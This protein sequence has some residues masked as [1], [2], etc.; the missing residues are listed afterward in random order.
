MAEIDLKEEHSS[1]GADKAINPDLRS[2]VDKKLYDSKDSQGQAALNGFGTSQKV[3]HPYDTPKQVARS[4]DQTT[5]AN[6]CIVKLGR[7]RK[8]NIYSGTGGTHQ[9][10][11]AAIDLVA[12]PMGQ[13]GKSHTKKNQEI[14]VDPSFTHDAARVYISQKADIDDYLDITEGIRSTSL[15]SPK[16]AVA[17]KAD[18]IRLVGREN[19]KLIT[20][21]DAENSQGGSLTGAYTGDYGIQLVA[22]NDDSDLQPMV[23]GTNLQEC[24]GEIIDNINDLRELFKNFVV[25]D[26]ALTQA[27]I[28]HTHRSPFYGMLTSPDFETL[29]PDGIES[30]IN[31]LTNVELQLNTQMQ[32]M[33]S[34][35]LNYLETPGG[36][37]TVNGCVGKFILSKYNITN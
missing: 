6:G 8:N 22:M 27:L 23:K 33:N 37:E 36:S 4:G 29:M 7:D 30:M 16:S 3:G 32:K 14:S 26:R 5:E 10:H 28:K 11:A 15:D 31:K 24:L 19:I 2:D 18:V 13:Y 20:R 35:Q 1:A 21:T 17:L 9:S 12:G 34:V 25:E